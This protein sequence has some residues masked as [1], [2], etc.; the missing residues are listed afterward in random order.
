[1]RAPRN[2]DEVVGWLAKFLAWIERRLDEK[3]ERDTQL[4]AVYLVSQDGTTYKVT[5][6]DAGALQ[7]EQV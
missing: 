6:S 4:E 1:M 2:E 5:V 7:T 3:T